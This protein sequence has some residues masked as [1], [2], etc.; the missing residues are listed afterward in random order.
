MTGTEVERIEHHG[1]SA[2]ENFV[3]GKVLEAVQHPDA[4]RL[5]VCQV[6]TGDGAE[7]SQ[8]VCGAPN[9][10]DRPD[11]RGRQAGRGDARRHQAQGR[12]AARP[13]VARDDP[14]RGRGRDRHRS[15]RDHGARRRAGRRYAAGRGAADLDRRARRSRSRPTGP[16]ASASTGSRGRRTPP[17]ARRW[18][19]RRGAHDPGAPAARSPAPR[20]PS[21]APTCARASPRACSRTS[22]IGESPA[23]LKARLMAAGQRPISNVVDITNYVMLLSGQAAAR[24]RPRSR[25]RRRS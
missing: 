14:G 17:P 23:W 16:T 13:A 4:D 15:R 1:V 19:R 18:R 2:L 12:Q 11:G 25:R 22:T 24:V 21:S 6:D 20:S 9:V 10:A 3:V 5:R 8:I 7:P